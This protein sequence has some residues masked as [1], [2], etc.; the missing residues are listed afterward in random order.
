MNRAVTSPRVHEPFGRYSIAVESNGMLFMS[1]Q[2]PFDKDK[3][4]VGDTI[5]SQAKQT[6]DNVKFILEDNGYSLAD[7][8]K[9][10]V[11]L[12]DIGLWAAFNEV[13]ASYFTTEPL[14][15]R[16]VVGCSLNGM[17]VELDC[18]VVKSTG[19]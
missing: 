16:T 15:A 10:T 5:D 6:L 12:E 2:G 3:R 1:G 17:L 19:M 11:Y 13:Y 9:V 8:V 14:P 18:I 7:V 4:L